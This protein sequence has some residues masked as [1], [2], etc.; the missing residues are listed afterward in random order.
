VIGEAV[1]VTPPDR[2]RRIRAVLDGLG[3]GTTPLPYSLETV[4]DHLA[5]DKKHAARRLRWVLPSESGVE[6][7]DDVPLDTVRH[8][9]GMLLAA[10]SPA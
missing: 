2:G 7:R 9:A 10:G 6:V 5:A 8:A 4:L 1:G 3:L